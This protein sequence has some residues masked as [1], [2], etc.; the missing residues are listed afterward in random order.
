M[1]NVVNLGVG[2]DT[3]VDLEAPVDN[4]G[5]EWIDVGTVGTADVSRPDV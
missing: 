4:D 2:V 5:T 3:D 1:V